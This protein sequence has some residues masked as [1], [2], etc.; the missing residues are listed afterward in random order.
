MTTTMNPSR[1]RRLL[2][3]YAVAVPLTATGAPLW[4]IGTADNSAAEFALS[5]DRYQ[6]FERPGFFVVGESS[7]AA[8]WPFILPGP[9]DS[10][11]APRGPHTC[12]VWFALQT[13]PTADSTLVLNLADTHNHA[14]P[15][16]S[17]AINGRA[18]E[19]ATP[20]GAGNHQNPAQ[21]SA[22]SARIPV[23]PGDLKVGIN[24]VAITVSR[25]SWLIWDHLAFEAGPGA[26]AGKLADHSATSIEDLG[27]GPDLFWKD[28]KKVRHIQAKI[29]HLGPPVTANLSA[30]DT[31]ERVE[32]T[33]GVNRAT[34]AVPD[35]AEPTKL[36]VKL[37]LGGKV[38]ATAALDIAPAREWTI[39]LVHQTHL[40]IGYTHVQEEVL[41][42]QVRYFREA[43]ALIEKT[44]DYPEGARFIW[45]PEGMWAVDEFMRVA[46]DDER[47]AFLK[48]CRERSIH[49]DV[50]YAQAMSGLYSEEELM[51][52]MAG[53]KL[54]ARE[55]GV[56][57]DSA[58]QSDVPGYTWGLA[59]ALAAHGVRHISLGPNASHRI[60]HTFHWGDRPFYWETPDGKDKVFFWMPRTGYSLFQGSSPGRYD[61]VE[62]NQLLAR[63]H[64]V[65]NYLRSLEESG[66]PY[67]MVMIRYSIGSDNGPPDPT[68]PDVIVEWNKIHA[69]PRIVI[70]S[71]S[72]VM[73]TF[74][75]RYGDTLPIMRGDF[76][77]YWEDGAASTS[78][79]TSACRRA[80]ERLAQ[81][82]VLW[83]MNNPGLA[84]HERFDTAWNKLIMFDE[85]TWGAWNSISAP[86]SEFAI[87]QDQYK[88]AYAFDGS[89]LTDELLA[90]IA[91][92]RAGSSAVDVH[93]TASWTRRGLVLLAPGQ[94]KA[95]DL[96][97]D[98]NGGLV[99][100]QRLASGE[101]AIL[102]S[103]IPAFGTR[104]YTL[105]PGTP[106]PG[107]AAK[108]DG[109]RISNGLLAATIEPQSGAISSLRHKDG[110][111]FEWVDSSAASGL[112]HYLYILGRNANKGRSTI[113]GPVNIA[114]EDAGPLVATLR[115]ESTAPGAA[116]LV[117]RVRMIDGQDHLELVN[118]VDKLKVR[119]PEG[120]YFGFP[121]NLPGAKPRVDTPWATVEVET[122]QLPGANRNFYCVQRFVDLAGGGRG[123]TW[124][125]VDAPLVQFD[126]IR[127]APA[128]GP[129]A[130][131]EFIDPPPFLWSWTMNNHWETNYKADQKGK[132]TFHYAL[133]P[134]TG[135]YNEAAAQQFGR[136]ICQPLLA[137]PA[138]P[139][140]K[141]AQPM[142]ALKSADTVVATQVRPSRDGKAWM[143]RLFNTGDQPATATL[144][145]NR[146]AGRT[147]LS[148][149]M[150]DALELAPEKIATAAR[151]FVT[152]RV[153]R[154][155]E[156]TS[157]T[158]KRLNW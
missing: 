91:P 152:L 132:I 69:S 25:G 9:K 106:A 115:I 18:I 29:F 27:V 66:Y 14:P 8:D 67:D 62:N 154:P 122:E 158:G 149:P 94:S 55:H 104:R 28:G 39:H 82:Q 123:V 96:V 4:Q 151:G 141:P 58:M 105:H 100:S 17:I 73:R 128:R 43:L 54:F 16:L 35:V 31:R 125:T 52:L 15:K 111:D 107:G 6:D 78:V 133:R 63:M 95:G 93:N 140:K 80:S 139:E 110:G 148:N 40:D 64:L 113:N 48:A 90:E 46:T 22:H 89:R 50:L 72:N 1:F 108:A 74:E 153:E 59:S 117:R 32:L 138:D 121:F 102:T 92:E 77:P 147:W 51:E 33:R 87:R 145:W 114:I 68:L 155:K 109:N 56:T 81:A 130:F 21:G 134:Y 97:R 88:Q 11:W 61:G 23:A 157:T 103:D 101:L 79:A 36:E 42:T 12:H 60:G 98:E 7:P 146:P 75:Q 5:P 34:I 65:R 127:I 83:S 118:T 37:H 120:V 135:D 143:V 49:L 2:L 24:H 30:N 76:T 38:A 57:I 53:A 116:G 20:A 70:D 86:D 112:N 44:R 3:L 150:E 142:L 45:H 124:V 131:R 10:A 84:L 136:N 85:H 47:A 99:P 119:K 41:A 137:V 19:Y 71:N 144:T 129:A 26:T 126:P 13:L 156:S